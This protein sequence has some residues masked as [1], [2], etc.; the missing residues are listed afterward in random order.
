M[1]FLF[2]FYSLFTFEFLLQITALCATLAYAK[3]QYSYPAPAGPS[4]PSVNYA[5]PIVGQSFG[6]GT[7]NCIH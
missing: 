5:A 7:N 4:L 3:P 1:L 6:G 2:F